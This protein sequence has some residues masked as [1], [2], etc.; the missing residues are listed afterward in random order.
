MH[1]LHKEN[2]SHMHKAG[3]EE[4]NSETMMW[5]PGHKWLQQLS[6]AR[7]M[8]SP[9]IGRSHRHGGWQVDEVGLQMYE[10]RIGLTLMNKEMA[11]KDMLTKPKV[12][13]AFI[14]TYNTLYDK[15][16]NPDQG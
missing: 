14:H 16:E 7:L 8:N 10:R 3:G 12:Y 6:E 9:A 5:K 1:E 2:T 15:V 11:A 4:T 13:K